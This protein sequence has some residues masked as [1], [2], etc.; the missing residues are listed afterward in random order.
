[1]APKTLRTPPRR[2][3]RATF[4]DELRDAIE[5][6]DLTPYALGKAAGIDPGILSRFL[7]GRRGVTSDTIDRI[8]FALGLH[9]GTATRGKGRPRIEK[10]GTGPGVADAPETEPPATTDELVAYE[11]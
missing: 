7:A 5:R 6:S 9:L 10:Q 4:S 1:M 2:T 3:A 8:A 11:G